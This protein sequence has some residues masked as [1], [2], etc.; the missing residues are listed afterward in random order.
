MK[1]YC[2]PLNIEYK[3]QYLRRLRHGGANKATVYREAAD[4]SLV[5]FKGLYYLFPS[6]TAGFLTSEDLVEWSFHELGDNIP[7]YDYAPDVRVIGDYLYF[8]A[9]KMRGTCSFFRSKNPLAEPFVEIK[10]TFT[11]WDPNLFL[12]DDGRLY[13][14]WGASNM[15]PIYG[16]ELDAQTMKPKSDPMVLLGSDKASRGYERIGDD[17]IPPKTEEEI[18]AQAEAMV[19]QMMSAPEEQRQAQG[20]ATEAD[21]KK[22]ALLVMG[23]NP[24]IEGSWMTKHKG[25]YYLQYAAPG[26]E[27]NIYAD[28]VYVSSSP[29]GPFTLAKNNPYS[30]K[31][32]GFINGAGHGSTLED[33]DG[34]FWHSS[35]MSISINETVERRLG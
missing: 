15:T 4:P 28:A 7:I 8:C 31:P 14:Y 16:V 18:E 33:K 9:S 11:F 32:G 29:L 5:L 23:N 6:M 20:L 13:F 25:V 12:D 27:Y 2:N 19:H 30:Y 1:Y 3:Y 24:Y 22:M 34:R 21:A 10:G 26:T 17:H 35:T